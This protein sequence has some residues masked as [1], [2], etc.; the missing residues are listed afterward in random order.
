[1]SPPEPGIAA[2]RHPLAVSW[3]ADYIYGTIATLVAIAGLTFE[4]NPGALTTACVVVIGAVAIWLA[5]GLSQLVSRRAFGHRA[6]TR[7]DVWAELRTSWA[8]VSAA[9][10]ATAV[11]VLAGMG[12]WS[13][14]QAFWVADGVGIGA[15]A[16]VGVGTAGGPDRPLHR[17][18][19]YVVGVVG[20]GVAI[21]LLEAGIHLL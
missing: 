16:V 3:L 6:L 17:R 9:L 7:R 5:H 15:L 2:P 12:L 1:V 18:I 19:A 14:R 11:F 13:M 10:P 4:V 8:I 21:V 20:V